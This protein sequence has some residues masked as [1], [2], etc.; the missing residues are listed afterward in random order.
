M[1]P[2]G[3]PLAQACPIDA[4]WLGV[5]I[6]LEPDQ[7]AGADRARRTVHPIWIS[8]APALAEGLR[9]V[10]HPPRESFLQRLQSSEEGRWSHRQAHCGALGVACTR[11][12]PGG[13]SHADVILIVPT[14]RD[15]V[16][17][18]RSAERPN[19]AQADTTK[20]SASLPTTS[21]PPH[22]RRAHENLFPGKRAF[23][24]FC[25]DFAKPCPV[26]TATYNRPVRKIGYVHSD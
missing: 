16:Y 7:A 26:W 12:T 8:M 18:I 23:T 13:H 15:G 5:T 10:P 4:G 2:L 3:T 6:R 17:R 11:S 9:S 14:T 25:S 22:S 21:H 19:P 20:G 24:A 1:N